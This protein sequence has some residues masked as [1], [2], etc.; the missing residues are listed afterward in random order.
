MIKTAKEAILGKKSQPQSSENLEK[1][2]QQE[3]KPKSQQDSGRKIP[4]NPE[5]L[6]ADPNN[7]HVRLIIKGLES[8]GKVE[9]GNSSSTP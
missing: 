8:E 3:P 2:S 4:T 9:T 5:H 1:T 6:P 7:L